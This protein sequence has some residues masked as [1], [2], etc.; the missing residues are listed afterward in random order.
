MKHATQ[1]ARKIRRLFAR[2]KRQYGTPKRENTVDPVDQ[3]MLS[4]LHR[5]TTVAKAQKVLSRLRSSMVDLNELRVSNPPELIELMGPA[6]PHAAEKAQQLI[7]VLNQVYK[8]HHG[9]GTDP[10]KDKNRRE[11]RRFVDSLKD[12]DP[13]VLAGVLLFS[14]GAH[15]IPVDENMLAV[16]RA[17]GLVDPQAETAEVQAFLERNVP[18]SESYAFTSLFRRYSEERIRSI[19]VPAVRDRRE[20]AQPQRAAEP[21]AEVAPSGTPAPKK[22]AAKNAP[23]GLRSGPTSKQASAK[24][25]VGTPA[26]G[27]RKGPSTAAVRKGPK[28]ARKGR[29][30]SGARSK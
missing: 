27:V 29:S 11:A 3:L 26:K 28:P 24:T 12:L 25:G 18:A 4:V 21:A 9:L 19:P 20:S 2:L 17:E 10:L 15:A 13:P 16:L 7:G 30:G 5:G 23:K 6:F 14:L 22:A 8:R 1:Y